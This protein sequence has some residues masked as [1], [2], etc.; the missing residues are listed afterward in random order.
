M[1]KYNLSWCRSAAAIAALAVGFV[2]CDTISG[3]GGPGSSP[4]TPPPPPA[5]PKN[6]SLEISLQFRDS[7]DPASDSLAIEAELRPRKQTDGSARVV[8]NDTLVVLGRKLVP[9]QEDDGA[10]VYRASL[11]IDASAFG[12][13]P[14]TVQAP[15]IEGVVPGSPK[16]VVHAISRRDP[17]FLMTEPSGKMRL[18]LGVPAGLEEPESG[19]GWELLVSD[20]EG[21]EEV[22]SMSAFGV[23]LPVLALTPSLLPKSTDGTLYSFLRF[24]QETLV[25][26]GEDDGYLMTL[27]LM[28]NLRW[29]VQIGRPQ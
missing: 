12:A 22:V 7:E 19:M 8:L 28:V 24:Q 16:T 21:D 10:L 14:V 11:E 6:A 3:T 29:N 26:R 27:R 25:G 23:P 13:V 5:P 15:T 4:Q 9:L 1:T 2:A 18:R 20:D 17:E